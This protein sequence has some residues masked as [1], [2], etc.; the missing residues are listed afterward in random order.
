MPKKMHPLTRRKPFLRGLPE[1]AEAT[2]QAFAR[3][4]FRAFYHPPESLL[5][6]ICILFSDRIDLTLLALPERVFHPPACITA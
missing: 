1:W 3:S 6:P 2:H 5:L 4:Q